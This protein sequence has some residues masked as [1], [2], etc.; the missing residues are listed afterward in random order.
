MNKTIAIQN[1]IGLLMCLALS[2]SCTSGN[3]PG[4][5]ETYEKNTFGYD[6]DFLSK[7]KQTICF[8][9]AQQITDQIYL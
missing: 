5:T 9:M 2:M 6:L 8:R 3:K 7:Y 1:Y 4:Q